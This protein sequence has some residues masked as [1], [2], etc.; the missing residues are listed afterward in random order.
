V[1]HA[2]L[3]VDLVLQFFGCH[4]HDG[5]APMRE[6]VDELRATRAGDLRRLGLG[7]LACEYQSRAAATRIS[8]TN[9]VGDKRSAES[10]PSGTSTVIVGISLASPAS[11]YRGGG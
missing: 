3:T 2:S 9:S 10:A 11:G 8:F 5:D 4:L 1:T 6:L 7:E